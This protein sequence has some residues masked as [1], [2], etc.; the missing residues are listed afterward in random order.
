MASRLPSID[1]TK[2]LAKKR[3]DDKAD[4]IKRLFAIAISVGFA[5]TLTRMHWLEA[6]QFPDDVERG[7]LALLLAGLVATAGSW[8]GYFAS[9]SEKPLRHTMRYVIDI[10]LVF[11]YMI[12]LLGASHGA[13]WSICLGFSF[14]LYVLWDVITVTEYLPLYARDVGPSVTGLSRVSA[15]FL[16]Y[17]N[18]ALDIEECRKG[19]I[20]TLCWAAYFTIF[21]AVYLTTNMEWQNLYFALFATFGLLAYRT[22]KNYPGPGEIRGWDMRLRAAIIISLAGYLLLGAHSLALNYGVPS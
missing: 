10:T 5:T 22:D 17:R 7:Q 11:T 13:L 18:A 15:V 3:S 1:E 9:I 19:P 16:V 8:D 4:F 20:I 21:T 12:L 6:G 2:E 14:A